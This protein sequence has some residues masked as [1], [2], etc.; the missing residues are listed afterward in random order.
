MTIP[1]FLQ[2]LR[3]QEF[4][5]P[6]LSIITSLIIGAVIIH[7]SGLN[8]YNAYKGLWQGAFGKP[9]AIAETFVI[10]TPYILSGLARFC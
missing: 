2:K 9:R 1:K 6:L 5:I 10:T 7:L 3:Y 4:V 8:V